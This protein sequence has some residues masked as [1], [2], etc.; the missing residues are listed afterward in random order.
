MPFATLNGITVPVLADTF[1][2]TTERVGSFNGRSS[3][4]ARRDSMRVQ[5][6]TWAGRTVIRSRDE[7]DAWR[8]LIDGHGHVWHF[9][10]SSELSVGGIGPD[11]QCWHRASLAHERD[12]RRVDD[13]GSSLWS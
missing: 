11:L 4:G 8:R 6:R 12:H 5:P 10:D 13:A 9:D 1:V 7:I 3:S 2:D